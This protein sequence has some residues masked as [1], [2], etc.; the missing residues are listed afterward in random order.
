MWKSPVNTDAA[1]IVG[2]T[3]E[4]MPRPS[5]DGIE[6]DDLAD[7]VPDDDQSDGY[8]DGHPI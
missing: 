8:S 7:A 1:D 5:H 6:P 4:Q 3:G 2:P